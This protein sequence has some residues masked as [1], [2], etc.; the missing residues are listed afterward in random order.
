MFLVLNWWL[1]MADDRWQLGVIRWA[2]PWGAGGLMVNRRVGYSANAEWPVIGQWTVWVD[3]QWLFWFIGWFFS[4]CFVVVHKLSSSLVGVSED[5]LWRCYDNRKGLVKNGPWPTIMTTMSHWFSFKKSAGDDGSD[6]SS[7]LRLFVSEGQQ[8]IT[9]N[10][11]QQKRSSCFPHGRG[12][13]LRD[14]WKWR[15]MMFQSSLANN[16]QNNP[17]IVCSH[18]C[19]WLTHVHD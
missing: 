5:S 17:G 7:L 8:M 13:R 16:H 15:Q 1:I 11:S 3:D 10:D 6:Y 12:W 19:G 4:T 9:T 2:K 18:D 14:E